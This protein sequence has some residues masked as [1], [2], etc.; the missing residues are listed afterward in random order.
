MYLF[1]YLFIL[2]LDSIIPTKRTDYETKSLLVGL[3]SVVIQ[4]LHNSNL[5]TLSTPTIS[6][7]PSLKIWVSY[8]LVSHMLFYM[9]CDN[10]TFG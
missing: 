9:H 4:R 3:V 8:D 7:K 5:L 10:T 2:S 6:S 1:I